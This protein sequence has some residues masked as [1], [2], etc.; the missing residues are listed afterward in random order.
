MRMVV[1]ISRL[2]IFCSQPKKKEDISMMPLSAGYDS[3]S[4]EQPLDGVVLIPHPLLKRGVYA[5][6]SAA[7]CR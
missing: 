4:L 6:L 1:C 3:R 7:L 5:T 2:I